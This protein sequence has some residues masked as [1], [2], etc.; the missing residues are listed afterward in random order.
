MSFGH[1]CL[2]EWSVKKEVKMI[3]LNKS[4]IVTMNVWR[5]LFT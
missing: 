2:M 5:V 4:E 1:I 3:V